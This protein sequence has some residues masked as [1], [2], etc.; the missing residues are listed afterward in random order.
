MKLNDAG[1]R[2]ITE[3]EGLVLHP[4]LDSVKVPTIGFGSTYYADG[5]RV[6]MLDKPITKDQ[7]FELF[8]LVA[9]RFALRVS[10]LITSAV[11]QN[12]FNAC[13]SIAYNIGMGNFGGSTLLKKVNANPND[14][15]ISAEFKKWNKA[16]GKVVTGLVNRRQKEALIYFT[17]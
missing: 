10:K 1:Y 9:D 16:G 13:V 8:K 11:N 4:Y 12:Q 7:A 2:L 3:F 5:R 6:T 17:K 14:I 15:T